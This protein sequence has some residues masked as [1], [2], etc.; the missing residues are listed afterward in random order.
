MSERMETVPLKLLGRFALELPY[1][2]RDLMIATR[3]HGVYVIGQYRTGAETIPQFS[4]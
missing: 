3:D 4:Q 2:L 1:N